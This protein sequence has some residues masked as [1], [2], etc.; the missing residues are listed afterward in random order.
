MSTMSAN[1]FRRFNA[2]RMS[3]SE[4][5]EFL[6]ELVGEDDEEVVEPFGDGDSDDDP[7]YVP[8]RELQT[9]RRMVDCEFFPLNICLHRFFFSSHS[10]VCISISIHYS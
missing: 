9:V 7:S 6:A 8:E 1:Q 3:Y 5:E 10:I 2:G 4:R